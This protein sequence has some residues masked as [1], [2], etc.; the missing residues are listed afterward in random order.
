ME[1][2][3]NNRSCVRQ[4]FHGMSPIERS[5]SI[6]YLLLCLFFFD[7]AWSGGGRYLTICGI[8]PR[9]LLG[10]LA[11]LLT[12]PVFIRDFRKLWKNP[13][14]L[15]LLCFWL[16]IAVCAVRGFAAGSRTDVLMSDLKGFAWFFLLPVCIALIRAKDQLHRLLSFVLA[17]ALVQAVLS[18]ACNVACALLTGLVFPLGEWTLA[19]Q[20]G[21]ASSI[22]D[23]LFRIFFYSSPYLILACV[24]LV[25]RQAERF[26][27]F[28]VLETALCL[29]ALVMTFTRSLYGAAAISAALTIA[30]AAFLHR[31]ALRPLFTHLVLSAVLALTLLGVQAV[32]FQTSYMNF[33]I[34]RSIGR[35]VTISR[36]AE[37][38][39]KLEA[40]FHIDLS[41]PGTEA[42]LTEEEILENQ[43]RAEEY[44]R[45]T[46]ASDLRRAVTE[47]ELHALISQNPLFGNGLGAA[48]PS[49][50]SGL[51]ELFYLDTVCRTGVLGLL[52]YLA[53]MAWLLFCV[54]R[55][56]CRTGPDI[57]CLQFSVLC[58]LTALMIATG[59][60]PWMNAVLGIAWYSL[61]AALPGIGR[62]LPPAEKEKE[63]CK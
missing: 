30:L 11:A 2:K 12:L 48:I 47:Q 34:S 43:R 55:D 26:R 51:D 35:E 44:L 13:A 32:L 6:A 45:I 29:S 5:A 8:T 28:Y 57:Q 58:G 19:L 1:M 62:D 25:F 50:E 53:P 37:V 52:L 9:M 17:G 39:G 49:R 36:A 10:G 14:I 42:P 22:S 27:L 38:R 23:S 18:L 46:T 59:F 21:T 56:L 20:L 41:V 3:T 15:L 60:N 16:W 7:C 63:L 40:H 61:A 31:R 4:R 24:I 33:A 54:I